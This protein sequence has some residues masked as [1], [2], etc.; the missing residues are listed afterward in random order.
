MRPP[1]KRDSSPATAD[2]IKMAL[3]EAHYDQNHRGRLMAEEKKVFTPLR[4]R[5]H[6]AH[7]EE[8]M[9][10]DD[11]YTEYIERLGLLPFITLVTRS[12]PAMNPCAITAL[13]DRWRPE[14]HTFHL[15]CGEMTVTLQDVSM[16]LALPISGAPLCFSTNSKGWRDSMRSLIGCAPLVKDMPAGAPY[17]WISLRY[18]RCPELATKEVVQQYARAYVWYVISRTLFADSGGRNAPYMWLKALTSWDS[19]ISWGTAALAYLYRQLDETCR[20]S[21][22]QACIGGPLLLLSVWMWTRLLVGRPDV[23]PHDDWD[24]YGM[25]QCRPTWAFLYDKVEPY[26][27]KTKTM[28]K[29]YSN[30]FDSLTPGM[31]NWEPY[32]KAENFARIYE[33]DLNPQCTAEA[34]LWRIQCPLICLYAVEYHLPQRV[35]TQFG[36]FQETPPEWKD[37]SIDLHR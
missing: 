18:K 14:T 2:D 17:T 30:E 3:L 7:D 8:K 33:F 1:V 35:M 29:Y 20:R 5:S 6:E 26:V 15:G 10:Y 19:K 34:H 22:P 13:V 32:G 16:I 11:R 31:V 12:T 23:L 37:T 36:L 27:G 24:E 4:L 21:D 28:Y 25:R 9:E